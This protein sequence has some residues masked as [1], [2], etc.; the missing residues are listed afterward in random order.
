MDIQLFKEYMASDNKEADF[1]N[2]G[3]IQT[4]ANKRDI[5]IYKIYNEGRNLKI[6][7]SNNYNYKEFITLVD[8]KTQE[9][10]IFMNGY[11]NIM[12]DEKEYYFFS[13]KNHIKF[14]PTINPIDNVIYEFIRTEKITEPYN[15]Y[16]HY[17]KSVT[18][19]HDMELMLEMVG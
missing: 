13:E 2:L 10:L 17:F 8:I 6:K 14:K 4:L 18:D 15:T 7:I 3:V 1:P 19:K 16:S 11:I 9:K 12:F 5:D